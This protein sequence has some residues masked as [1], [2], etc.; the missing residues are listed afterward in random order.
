M[1]HRYTGDD[2]RRSGGI[3]INCDQLGIFNLRKRLFI[4][5]VIPKLHFEA[6]IRNNVSTI[7]AAMTEDV[8][9]CFVR[10]VHDRHFD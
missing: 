7:Q 9:P 2:A 3:L 10:I 1:R 8:Q 4:P 5:L 6:V